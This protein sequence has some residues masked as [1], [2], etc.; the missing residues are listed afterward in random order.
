MLDKI[1]K[2]FI[3]YW[4]LI[5][6]FGVYIFL[7]LY[8]LSS[9]PYGLHIDEVGMAYDAFNLS[10]SGIDRYM[11]SFPVYLINSGGGQSILYCYICIFL[12]KFLPL[13]VLTIRIPAFI[14]A[15]IIFIY[16]SL[17]I[18][19]IFK[20]KKIVY[21]YAI[22]ITIMPY[23]FMATRFGL[24]CNLMLG[25]SIMFLYYL[26]K[27]FANSKISNYI[28]AGI[29]GGICLYT[30]ALSY[31][32]LPL[33]IILVLLYLLY[34]KKF[35][36]KK[37]IFF[38]T[39]M[40]IISI[41]LLIFHVVNLFKLGD[42]HILGITFN[43]LPGYRVNELSI[44]NIF[45][46]VLPLSKSIFFFDWLSY[47]TLPEFGTIYYISVL[48]FIIGFTI[49]IK[50]FIK[51]LRDKKLDNKSIIFIWF[52]SMI[53]MGLL[54]GGDGPNANKLN[55]IFFAIVFYVVIGLSK[56]K[57]NKITIILLIIIYSYSFLS[58]TNFYFHKYNDYYYHQFL[59]EPSFQDVLKDLNTN[60]KIKD[61]ITY[62]DIEPIYYLWEDKID[63]KK[64]KNTNWDPDVE[65][66]KF[67]NYRFY[68]LNNTNCLSNYIIKKDNEEYLQ[69][70][71]NCDLKKKSYKDY[72]LFYN[73]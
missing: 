10:K 19:D 37:F 66:F 26:N 64:L 45:K 42:L 4:L 71:S 20:S 22:M 3:N 67:L 7:H 2:L 35:N 43:Q 17:I 46:N 24:D 28:I 41:P 32:V 61:R 55:A 9:I 48:F 63:A 65:K 73:D 12:F 34:L 59:F 69:K 60:K 21:L 23:F 56:L 14:N 52:I 47:N 5:L 31:I 33:F 30:Y 6:I 53:L 70:L 11:N 16:G 13:S 25:M 18:K 68:L 39:P 38:I 62:M 44:L 29:I 49:Y 54:L 58:F 8:K 50:D 1:K 27:A 40:F 72:Y 36:F 15:L 57:K 51:Q